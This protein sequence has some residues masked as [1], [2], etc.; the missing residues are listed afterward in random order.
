MM[1]VY[2]NDNE[3]CEECGSTNVITLRDSKGQQYE[4]C[5]DCGHNSKE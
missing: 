4:H 2:F 3:T 5:N 1:K